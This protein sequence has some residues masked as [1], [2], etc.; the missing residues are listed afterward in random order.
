MIAIAM[1][2]GL[3]VVYAGVAFGIVIGYLMD[4]EGFE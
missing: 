2:T 3:L 4:G 1:I